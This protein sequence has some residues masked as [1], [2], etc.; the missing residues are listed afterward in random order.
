M[1]S[2]PLMR[3][4]TG[5]SVAPGW[6][7]EHRDSYPPLAADISVDTAIIGG[8]VVGLSCAMELADHGIDVALVERDIIACGSTGWCAG[9]LSRSTTLDVSLVEKAFGRETAQAISQ[10]VASTLERYSMRFAGAQWQAGST[11]YLAAK[12]GHVEILQQEQATRAAFGLNRASA[13]D[14]ELSTLLPGF[15]G[16]LKGEGEHGVNP[17]LL[18][19]SM[20]REAVSAGARI[21]EQT[22]VT[23]WHCADGFL[24]VQTTGGVIRARR[25]ILAVGL[26]GA[27]Q[28]ERQ[29]LNRFLIPVIGHVLITEPSQAIAEM[30][31]K[32][33]VIAAWDSLHLYHYARYLADGRMLV[34]GEELPGAIPGVPVAADDEHVRRLHTW[35]QQHH[36]FVVPPVQHAWRASLIFPGD[37]M[38][39]VQQRQVGGCP[40]V[41]VVT[42]GLPFAFALA[43]GIARKFSGGEDWLTDALSD[44]RKMTWPARL[45]SWLPQVKA[46]RTLAHHMAF[47]ALRVIDHV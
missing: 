7:P 16:V 39:L 1:D 42:D 15:F 37:G 44:K 33:G 24:V 28:K 17:V 31:A 23:S 34:G 21:Y 8:G 20:A 3:K 19:Q 18:M 35:A 6:D 41:T 36:N 25:L 32:H 40:V 45:L 2:A 29:H 9:V 12:P 47:A 4:T 38:P 43:A 14:A 5:V 26:S 27:S 11:L 46:L 10:A 22:A 13:A 30:S